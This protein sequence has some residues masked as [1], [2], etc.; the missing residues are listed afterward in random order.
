MQL[1][2]LFPVPVKCNLNLLKQ[3]QQAYLLN[4][5]KTF[6]V[7]FGKIKSCFLAKNIKLADS[8]FFSS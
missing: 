3:K 5:G 2:Q 4:F 1:F 6:N 8:Y 7:N